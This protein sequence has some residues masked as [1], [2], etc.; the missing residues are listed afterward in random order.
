MS[1]NLDRVDS[2][3]W[4]LLP[5]HHAIAN[6]TVH[7]HSWDAKFAGMP[8]ATDL[9]NHVFAPADDT[10][11]ACS[12]AKVVFKARD[13]DWSEVQRCWHLF[14]SFSINATAAV[15]TAAGHTGSFINCSS[16]F[17][18]TV[19]SILVIMS[20]IGFKI[21]GVICF[22]SDRAR[23]SGPAA[24]RPRLFVIWSICGSPISIFC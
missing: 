1:N 21:S 9:G 22:Q 19:S 14:A 23:P 18:S 5:H 12:C 24:F 4:Q 16:V 17:L 8:L 7:T 10:N 2:Q 6:S 11:E 20:L 3:P 13:C 15:L